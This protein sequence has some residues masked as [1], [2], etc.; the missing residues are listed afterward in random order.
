MLLVLKFEG[1]INDELSSIFRKDAFH[2]LQK[3]QKKSKKYLTC[4][5]IKIG[6]S[7]EQSISKMISAKNSTKPESFS[8]FGR[9]RRI[10]LAKSHG[11]TQ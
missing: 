3:L 8:G 2:F 7:L 1:L 10:D 9:D 11:Y 5:F 6:S 4:I